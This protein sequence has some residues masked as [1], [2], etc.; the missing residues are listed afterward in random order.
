[1]SLGITIVKYEGIFD[2]CKCFK[3]RS[4]LSSAFNMRL[5]R[6]KS[7]EL[8][9]NSDRDSEGHPSEKHIFLVALVLITKEIRVKSHDD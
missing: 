8:P 2:T 7:P 5:S 4:A 1:M 6:N 9:S 3:M